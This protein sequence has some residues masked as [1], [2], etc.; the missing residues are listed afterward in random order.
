MAQGVRGAARRPRLIALW[1]AAGALGAAHGPAQAA[2]SSEA[3]DAR[4]TIDAVLERFHGPLRGI[5]DRTMMELRSAPDDE[6]TQVVLALPGRMRVTEPDGTVRLLVDAAGWRCTGERPPERLG[7]ADLEEL[8]QLRDQMRAVLL[9]PLYRAEQVKDQGGGVYTLIL[10]KGETWRL[11]LDPA[12]HDPVELRGPTGPVRFESFKDTGETRPVERISVPERGVVWVKVVAA[13]V[14]LGDSVFSDP[15]SKVGDTAGRAGRVVPVNQ[16]SVEE[17]PRTP[18]VQS[19]PE[20]SYLVLADPGTWAER[21]ARIHAAASSLQE[22]GQAANGLPTYVTRDS[23]A[24]LLVPFRPD[25]AGGSKP[26]VRAADDE[27]LHVAAHSAVVLAPPRG[28][29]EQVL[30]RG[31]ADLQ[32]FL[33]ERRLQPSGPLRCIPYVQPEGTPSDAELRQLTVRLEQPVTQ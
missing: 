20:R 9:A 30:E 25:P 23:D 2:P 29:W 31:R 32:R 21:S 16:S 3:R 27:V 15:F 14:L 26:F 7:G 10:P 28:T 5:F 19:I 22:R 12:T 24:K 6:P 33:A 13:D 11:Q 18:E 1:L 8:Q 17:L 4:Q